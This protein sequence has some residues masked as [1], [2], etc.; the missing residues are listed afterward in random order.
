[1]RQLAVV[2]LNY[3]TRD[4]LRACLRSVLASSAR[5]ADQLSVA[6]L[7]VDSASTDG[8]AAMVAAEYP[9][10]HL[11][12]SPDNLGYTGGNNLA[13]QL[14]GFAVDA[15]AYT[16]TSEQ[17][18]PQTPDYVLLLNADT[19]LVADALWQLVKTLE[20]APA[21]AVCGARLQFGDGRFQHS[22][23]HFP[24]FLQLALDIFPWAEWPYLR[25]LWPRLYDSSLNGRYPAERWATDEPFAVDFVLGA[26]MLVRASAIRQVGGLDNEYFLYCE[27]MD[28]CLRLA[29][30]GWRVLAAPTARVIHHEG[31]SSRQVRWPAYVRLWQSRYR[32]YQK[33]RRRYPAGYVHFV[34]VLVRCGLALRTWSAYRR[35]ARGALTGDEVQNEITAY[36]AIA[37]L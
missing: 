19:E 8:S 24:T 35:F 2:I 11:V 25:Q 20:A 22:A 37:A 34:R 6:T 27:E 32:F 28:W 1:M 21:A 14:L 15:P 31:Q 12:A 3:N 26:A 33:H 10:V 5:T 9:D 18:L 17:P 16:E 13:L 29:N 36:R 7:V 30:A 4:L 23:F